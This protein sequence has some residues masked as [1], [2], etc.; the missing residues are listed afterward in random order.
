MAPGAPSTSSLYVTATFVHATDPCA[1]RPIEY[2]T[3]RHLDDGGPLNVSAVTHVVHIAKEFGPATMG[4]LGVMLTALAIAQSESP[5]LEVSVILPHYS[6]LDALDGA[7][8]IPLLQLSLPVRNGWRTAYHKV[9]CQISLLR[10]SYSSPGDFLSP[11]ADAPAP[12]VRKTIAIYLI[13]VGDRSPFDVAFKTSGPGEIYSALKPLPQEWKDLWF[14]K[15]AAALVLHLATFDVAHLHGATNAMVAYY[16]RLANRAPTIVYTL[17]DSLDEV[18]YTN[19]VGN[20]VRFLDPSHVSSVT[21]F[22]PRQLRYDTED[23]SDVGAASPLLPLAPWIHHERYRSLLR[24]DTRQLFTSALGID[25]A[26]QVTFVSR[27]IAADIVEG[28]FR[29][30]LESLVMP[31]LLHRARLGDFV[32]VTNGLDFTEQAKNPFTSER[33]LELGL[34]F[35]R[36]GPD[37]LGSSASLARVK[38]RAKEHVV[39]HLPQYFSTPDLTRPILLFIGRFQYNKGCEFFAPIIHL[40]ATTS[41]DARLVVIGARNNYPIEKLRRLAQEHQDRFT[42][43]EEWEVQREWGTVIRMASDYALVP[44]FSEA[45]GLVAAEGLLF[46]MPVISSGVG[47]LME[48]LSPLMMMPLTMMPTESRGNAYLFDLF[49]QRQESD[50]TLAAD[51]SRPNAAELAPGIRSCLLAVRSAI[52]DWTRRES[53]GAEEEKEMLVRRMVQMA[54]ALTWAREQGPIEE[55]CPSLSSNALTR[56]STSKFML[57]RSRIIARGAQRMN[58]NTD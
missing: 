8:S 51:T 24:T 22:H 30:S 15:A 50:L 33:L 32:G 52:K 19:L 27:S 49:P 54:L 4:G 28:R 40:L 34:A 57:V 14:A 39:A 5:L 55:V 17:H 18:E 10:W 43:I 37:L 13:G 45:F 7:R 9:N 2:S 6:F 44:S 26:D 46:G 35:P 53:A 58:S 11:L 29:F 47:G 25:L 41:F 56:D 21:P 31:S 20:V 48:Y 42:F 1:V 16:L 38:R 36:V 12:P 3:Y 23:F